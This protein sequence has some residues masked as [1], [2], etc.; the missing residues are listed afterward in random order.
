MDLG[1]CPKPT[2]NPFQDG[3]IDES[4]WDATGNS[5]KVTFD[6]AHIRYVGIQKD[7]SNS[8]EFIAKVAG[9]EFYETQT[10]V[11]AGSTSKICQ[12]QPSMPSL[13]H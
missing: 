13:T 11:D 5:S 8:Q 2:D 1:S 6:P 9:I 7:W 3:A 10:D 12:P 4:N